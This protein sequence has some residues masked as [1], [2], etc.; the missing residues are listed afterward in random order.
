MR[1]K[2]RIYKFFSSIRQGSVEGLCASADGLLT[3]T[4]SSDKALKV[5]DVINFGAQNVQ[6]TLSAFTIDL[7]MIN[8]FK[9]NFV[10]NCC[11]WIYPPGAPIAALAV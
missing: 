6:G 10:P 3:A 2:T 11:E 1:K 7:D 9:L 8:M 5:F 4:I